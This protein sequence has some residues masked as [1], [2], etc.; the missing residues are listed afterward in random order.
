MKNLF[1]WK[2]FM[3]KEKSFFAKNFLDEGNLF[4]KSLSMP[5]SSRANL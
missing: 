3:M 1:L 4:E 5:F 2:T